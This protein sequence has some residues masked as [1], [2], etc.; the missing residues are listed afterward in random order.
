MYRGEASHGAYRPGRAAVG[1]RVFTVAG[2]VDRVLWVSVV[3]VF[4][5]DGDSEIGVRV[6][7]FVVVR[8][9]PVERVR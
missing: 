3:A 1:F 8:L 9:P 5:G 7:R 6:G 2:H 4:G